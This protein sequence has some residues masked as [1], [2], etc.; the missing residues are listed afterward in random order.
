MVGSLFEV[1]FDFADHGDC[2]DDV[3]SIFDPLAVIELLADEEFTAKDEIGFRQESHHLLHV[4]DIDLGM[5]L[6]DI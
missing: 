2:D 5:N 3:A 1:F 6:L 4:G